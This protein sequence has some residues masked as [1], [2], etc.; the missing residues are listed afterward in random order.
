MFDAPMM[1]SLTPVALAALTVA[2]ESIVRVP[3]SVEPTRS[4]VLAVSVAPSRARGCVAA[5]SPSWVRLV[6]K[7][8]EKMLSPSISSVPTVAGPVMVCGVPL[9]GPRMEAVS[10]APGYPVT[11]LPVTS[12]QFGAEFEDVGSGPVDN[13][14]LKSG[15]EVLPCQAFC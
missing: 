15:H 1:S 11:E 8:P 14:P 5:A 13:L 10:P 6:E 9:D 3:L 7:S 12:V 2:P 4:C